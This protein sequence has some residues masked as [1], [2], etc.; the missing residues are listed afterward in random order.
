MQVRD[1]ERNKQN[2]KEEDKL[3]AK[4]ESIYY[5]TCY[6]RHLLL[7]KRPW[8]VVVCCG[9]LS[10]TMPIQDI[11]TVKLSTLDMHPSLHICRDTRCNP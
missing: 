2:Q 10:L 5:F 4:K 8:Q 3:G 6:I 11:C 7:Y 1:L 9:H